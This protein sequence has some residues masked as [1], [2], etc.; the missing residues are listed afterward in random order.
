MTLQLAED[1]KKL[2]NFALNI[3]KTLDESVVFSVITLADTILK[4]GDFVC[5]RYG[6][7]TQQWLIMLHLAHDPN[8]PNA[9]PEA[10]ASNTP[11]VA[12]KLAEK[13]NVSRPNITNLINSLSEKGLVEQIADKKDRRKKFLILTPEGAEIINKIEPHRH[14]ANRRLLEHLDNEQKEV[15]LQQLQ[16]CLLVLTSDFKKD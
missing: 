1:K 5:Q 6:I 3:E 10:A 7:T 2:A 13:L 8:I 15:L 16:A 11:V 12:S 14:Q 4:N 9:D